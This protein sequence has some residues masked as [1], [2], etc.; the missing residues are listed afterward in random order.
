MSLPHGT[1]PGSCKDKCIETGP[2]PKF[3]R[4]LDQSFFVIV[5]R[6]CVSVVLDQSFFVITQR[7]CVT[8]SS[9]PAQFSTYQGTLAKQPL[10]DHS[11]SFLPR[12]ALVIVTARKTQITPALALARTFRGKVTPVHCAL[13]SAL[14]PISATQTIHKDIT[15]CRG[16]PPATIEK[17][18]TPII[19]APTRE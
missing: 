1:S 11:F 10:G 19:A 18:G 3:G 12:G 2:K 9:S 14:Y 5:Q 17:P 6:G 15:L 7:G 4:A 16:V 13:S 8:V